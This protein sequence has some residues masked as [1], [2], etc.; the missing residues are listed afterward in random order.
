[1]PWE[2]FAKRVAE[3]QVWQ[4]VFRHGPPDT[5]RSRSL[6]VFS[7]FFL[8]LHPVSLP[9]GALRFT[10]TWGLGGTAQLLFLILAVSGILLMF[11]YV[12]DV[13]RAYESMKDLRFA[14]P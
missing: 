13:D 1:M 3:S 6:V 10:F 12:P 5:P 14:V 7:N 2:K 4:S 11:Y 9:K 8:H